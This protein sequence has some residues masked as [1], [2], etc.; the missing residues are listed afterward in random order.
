MSINFVAKSA[1]GDCNATERRLNGSDLI[2]SG[3]NLASFDSI[4]SV[5]RLRG[6]NVYSRH[7]SLLGLVILCLLGTG[8]TTSLGV[9]YV[10]LCRAFF[11]YYISH[12]LTS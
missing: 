8:K 11:K 10:G 9:L 2:T 1:L 4:Q 5:Q 7:Q 6:L 3:R 12:H